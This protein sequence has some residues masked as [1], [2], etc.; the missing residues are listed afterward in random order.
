MEKQTEYRGITQE[1]YYEVMKQYSTSMFNL[2]DT[3]RS[4]NSMKG[5]SLMWLGSWTASLIAREVIDEHLDKGSSLFDS[6]I[7]KLK[8]C[9]PERAKD[10]DLLLEPNK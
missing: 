6:L 2:F 5:S 10:L 8:E 3:D 9:S 1:Q 7:I 4:Y